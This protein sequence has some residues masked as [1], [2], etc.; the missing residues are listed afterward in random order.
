M[1][2]Y[3]RSEEILNDLVKVSLHQAGVFQSP[4]SL[5]STLPSELYSKQITEVLENFDVNTL[6]FEKLW[7]MFHQNFWSDSSVVPFRNSNV[8]YDGI[9]GMAY[10]RGD[11]KSDFVRINSKEL[12]TDDDTGEVEVYNL[13]SIYKVLSN[14]YSIGN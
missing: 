11:I 3:I 10:I 14:E 4:V 5:A 2:F 6:E 13:Q 7:E 12:F 8:E 9:T 1:E